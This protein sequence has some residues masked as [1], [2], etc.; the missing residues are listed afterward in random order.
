MLDQC[1]QEI[2][3]GQQRGFGSLA[4]ADLFLQLGIGFDELG[5]TLGDALL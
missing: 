4:L 2:A 3:L 5:G 1:A